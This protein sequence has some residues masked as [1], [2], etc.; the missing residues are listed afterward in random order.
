MLSKVD[1]E[2]DML[3]MLIGNYEG[4]SFIN[5]SLQCCNESEDCEEAVVEHIATKHHKTS[6]PRKPSLTKLF[7][8]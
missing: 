1:S 2:N 4:F 3:E 6:R 8:Q 7:R 5:S